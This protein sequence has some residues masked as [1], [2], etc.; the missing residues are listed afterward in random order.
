MPDRDDL[1]LMVEAAREAGA[2]AK[3]FF[4]NAPEIWEKP[5]GQGPVT[6]AD[7]AVDRMLRRDLRE[8]RRGYGWLSEETEDDLDRLR[9]DRVFIVDPIDGTRAFIEGSPTWALSLAVATKGRITAAAV[10]LPMSDKMYTA[11][12]GEGAALNDEPIQ[13]SHRTQLTGATV[14]AN[15][16]A[17]DAWHWKNAKAPDV[18]RNFRSSLAYRMALI[19]QGRFDAMLTLRATWEWDVAAGAL[20]IEEAGGKV[21]DKTGAPLVFN[22]EEPQLAGVVGSGLDIH[23]DLTDQLA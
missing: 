8:A 13:A 3:H 11:V 6:E 1:T 16:R 19:A 4:E 5:D 15:K 14:L 10:Y 9:A 12:A 17:F 21:T 2:I 18:K 7:I 20:L 22:R 23:S